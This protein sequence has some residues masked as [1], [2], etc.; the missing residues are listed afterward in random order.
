MLCALAAP[1]GQFAE[2]AGAWAWW[3]VHG[4]GIRGIQ[5]SVGEAADAAGAS[6]FL[7]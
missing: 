3:V 4:G 6:P 7:G 2:G 5:A 1:L